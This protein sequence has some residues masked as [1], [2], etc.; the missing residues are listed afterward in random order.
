MHFSSEYIQQV[1]DAN[2]IV[3]VVSEYV[4][5]KRAGGVLE[6]KCPFHQ[7][8]TP[9]F[10]VYQH[11]QSFYCYGCGKGSRNNGTGSDVIAFIQE[12][13]NLDWQ[14]AVLFLA[15]RAGIDP[16]QEQVTP[17]QKRELA[18]IEQLEELNRTFWRA[19]QQNE[20]AIK[21]LLEERGLTK[22]SINTWRIGFVPEDYRVPLVAGRIAIAI[23]NA[24]GRTV[25]FGYRAL[26]DGVPKYVN[27]KESP[28]FKKSRML[29]G[30]SQAK[31]GIR[32]KGYAV[33]T[34]GYFDAIMLHQCG[35][36]NAVALMG[37]ALSKDQA[38]LLASYADEAYL[39]LDNDDAGLAAAMKHITTLQSEGLRVKIVNSEFGDPADACKVLGD[40]IGLLV[41]NRAKY[42]AQYLWDEILERYRKQTINAKREALDGIKGLV[43][44][45][46]S[47]VERDMYVRQ[48]AM[49]LGLSVEALADELKQLQQTA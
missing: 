30:L 33:I 9:S 48:A 3:D 46:V 26:D 37:T 47:P 44:I 18:I 13:E 2:D 40:K 29:F 8:D 1:K 19:L 22:E 31:D 17:E 32:K 35:V 11:S 15:N 6:G 7:D 42:A 20:Q 14:E 24:S 27:S 10:K 41:E 39:F 5:L 49:T 21:Y 25:G 36:D 34:E 43:D 45:I 38:K 12:I 23:Q 16:P 4:E 28:V